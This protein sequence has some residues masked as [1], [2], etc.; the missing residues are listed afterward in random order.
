M[1][2]IAR[3][4][5]FTRRMTH[6]ESLVDP[7][8]GATV[9]SEHFSSPG[10]D[11]QPLPGDYVATVSNQ[12]TGGQSAVGYVDQLSRKSA[13]PGEKRIYGRN[14]EGAE[15]NQVW[16]R[17]DGSI[18]ISNAAGS[19]TMAADGSLNL[20][21]VTIGSTGVVS[22]PDSLLLKGAEVAGHGHGAGDL[23]DSGGDP[24][25]GNTADLA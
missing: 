11:S 21:G 17:R 24:C 25:T 22:V 7:G 19:L 15:V 4:V 10:D 8:G 12:R 3:L 9:T 14:A 23:L 6:S 2:L 1:G 18:Q 5:S 20:N 13:N 16:L